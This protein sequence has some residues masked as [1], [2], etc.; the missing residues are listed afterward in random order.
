[1]LP[2]PGACDVEEASFALEI[3]DVVYRKLPLAARGSKRMFAPTSTGPYIVKGQK[4]NSS[5][6]LETPEGDLL[7]GG[8]NIPL[9]Q[10]L[11]GSKP[12]HVT[13]PTESEVT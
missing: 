3:G 4:S 10:V 11:P 2:G 12:K 5:V 6:I 9:T 8:G 1:M 7:E 13:V